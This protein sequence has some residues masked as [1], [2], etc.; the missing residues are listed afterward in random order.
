MWKTC[1][2]SRPGAVDERTQISTVVFL[3]QPNLFIIYFTY[4]TNDYDFFFLRNIIINFTTQLKSEL[5]H[6][7]LAETA[8]QNETPE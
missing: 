8:V 3:T 7:L 1:K 4:H 6:I 5:L 2:T